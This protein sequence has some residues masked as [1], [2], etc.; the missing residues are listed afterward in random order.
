MTRVSRDQLAFSSGEISPLLRA[1]RDYQRYQTGLAA[2]V[3][4][5]P[6]RQGGVTRAPGTIFRGYTRD[7]AKARLISFEFARNDAVVLEFTAGWMRVWRYGQLV[8]NAA[9]TAPYQLAHPYSEADLETLQ[10]AQSAD[11]IYLAGGGKPMQRLARYGLANWTIGP[12]AFTGGPFRVQNLDESRAISASAPAGNVTLTANW[13]FFEASH[14]GSLLRIEAQHYTN[15]P[16]W[17]G[18]IEMLLGSLVRSDGKIYQLVQPHASPPAGVPTFTIGS[19]TY[20]AGTTTG[21]K[22]PTGVNPPIHTSGVEQMSVSPTIH[23]RYLGDGR[24]IVRITGVNSP[25][26]ATATVIKRLPESIDRDPTYRWSEGAWSLRFGYPTCLEIHDQRLVAAASPSDPRTVWFSAVGDFE[27]FEPGTEADSAFAYGISGVTSQNRV[28]W[29]KAGRA[30]LHIGALGEEYSARGE[31]TQA[32][33]PANAFFGFDS[34]IGSKEHARPVAPD[35][36]PIFISKDGGRVVEIAYDLQSDANRAME[37]SLPSEHLGAL[38]FREIAW[39]S[40]PLRL[41]WLRCANGEL[42]VM[43]YD[44]S[45][46][47]LGWARYPVAGGAVESMAVTP[48]ADAT[49]DT[50]TMVTA[51]EVNG[52]LVR[53]VEEQAQNLGV[54]SG[55][56]PLHAA[57]HLFACRRFVQAEPA[58]SFLVPHLAGETVYAWTDR[59]QYGPIE[60]PANGSVTLPVPVGNALIGLLDGKAILETLPIQ[61]EA[62]DGSARA[63]RKRLG[64]QT[65][66]S[67]HNTAALSAC[68]V[69]F[70]TAQPERAWPMAAL[71]PRQVAAVL[72]EAFSGT[73]RAGIV[74]GFA[75][76]VALRFQPVGG[77][78]ATLTGVTPVIIEGGL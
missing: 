25:T 2:C 23:W 61:P 70:D 27:D 13:P 16:L 59:G 8:Q 58:S 28:I 29:L 48:D 78:P 21:E 5:L 52:Q 49:Y 14:V 12:V 3:G 42:A 68:A 37:L 34:S 75:Q 72:T 6:L 63:R 45:E 67:L 57:V 43:V 77:A 20:V 60:V 54:L 73:V 36:R 41:A 47:V 33:G 18:N 39:Q 19:V 30:G 1:R 17:T 51:R 64:P 40:A 24:G 4:F 55:Q 32:I 50:L 10:W 53:M 22:I 69:E 65:G 35:G 31:K 38:G 62:P 66:I 56:Q 26:S 76:D 74:S 15:I 9:G 46:E 71:L 11:V 7:N 44:P